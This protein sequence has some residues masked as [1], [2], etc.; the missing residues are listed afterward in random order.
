LPTGRTVAA[1]QRVIAGLAVERRQLRVGE[2]TV[3]LV[4]AD[5][6]VAASRLD[7]DVVELVALEVEFRRPVVADIDV[8]RHRVTRPQPEREGV[9]RAGSGDGQR[10]AFAFAFSFAPAG[11]A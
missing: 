10:L 1:E 6:V 5:D 7:N 11:P 9:A 4:D 3:R 8:E 2:H